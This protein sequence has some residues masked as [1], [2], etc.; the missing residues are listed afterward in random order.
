MPLKAAVL[1]EIDQPLEIMDLRQ[2]P[3]KAQEVRVKTEVAGLC[4]SDYH[5]MKGTAI[6]PVP[7]V[8]GHEGAGIVTEVGKGV[9]R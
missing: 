1:Q 5:V 4:A 8:L 7:I 3:P 6:Q 2:D 9:T